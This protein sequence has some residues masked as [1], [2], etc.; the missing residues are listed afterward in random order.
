MKFLLI[1]LIFI[2]P[3]SLAACSEDKVDI[4]SAGLSDLDKLTGIGPVYA[5][6]IID[7]RPFSSLDDLINVKGI[8]PSTLEK[9]KSQGLACISSEETDEEKQIAVRE[10]ED[11]LEIQKFEDP[12]LNLASESK[13][14]S[15]ESII[16]L[17]SEEVISNSVQKEEVIFESKNEKV[18]RY[19]I[20]AFAFF[21][22]LIIILLLLTR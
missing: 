11:A 6:K 12:N 14:S 9:I 13:E 3:F 19:L 21:L 18:K 15:T 1:F 4:N 16:N 22:I 8:G 10:Q 2:I 5:Q 7:S 17:N 20:F